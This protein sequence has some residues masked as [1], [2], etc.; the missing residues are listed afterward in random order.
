MTRDGEVGGLG[1]YYNQ[2]KVEQVISG[3]QSSEFWKSDVRIAEW[4]WTEPIWLVRVIETL[5][6]KIRRASISRGYS[7][8]ITGHRRKRE[9]LIHS[10][11]HA[12]FV[13]QLPSHKLISTLDR[14]P[15]LSIYLQPSGI[16]GRLSIRGGY[17]CMWRVASREPLNQYG[18]HSTQRGRPD[19]HDA[20]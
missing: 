3:A 1:R 19:S 9:A 8:L 13:A 15:T 7:M 20:L 2:A 10:L 18:K 4:H 5:E 14:T 16:P 6:F 12:G 17:M 11:V